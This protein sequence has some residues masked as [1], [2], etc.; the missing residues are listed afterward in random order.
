MDL[1]WHR[2]DLRTWDNRAVYEANNFIPIYIIDTNLIN[3]DSNR[4]LQWILKNIDVLKQTYR[5]RD[6]DLIVRK[7]DPRDILPLI[8]EKYN[9]D[10]VHWN[11]S[12]TPIGK[13]RDTTV[14]S[15]LQNNEHTVKTYDSK[16][17]HSLDEITT[18][19]TKFGTYYNEWKSFDIDS[20]YEQVRQEDMH[21]FTD[22]YA[23]PDCSDIASI[24]KPDIPLPEPGIKAAR[25]LLGSFL[26]N[27]A[28]SYAENKDYPAEYN[29]SKLSF[30]L[31][32]GIIGIR[33]VMEQITIARAGC[34]DSQ[35]AN[36]NEFKKQIAWRDFYT[37]KMQRSTTS[38]YET[39][40]KYDSLWISQDNPH[41][42]MYL[43]K[44][45]NG[46]TG[47]PIIDAGMRE[48]QQTG[49]M[50]NRL[51][52]ATA[53]FLTNDLHISWEYGAKWFRKMLVDY[54]PANNSGGWKWISSIGKPSQEYYMIVNPINQGKQYDEDAEYIKRYVEELRDIPANKIHS[55]A[56]LSQEQRDKYEYPDPIIDHSEERSNTITRHEE[57]N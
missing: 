40:D 23:V 49:Y 31:S 34:T 33:E 36:I 25:N 50:H 18:S 44:W 21:T 9:I 27:R 48:L 51:R 52:M 5:D 4:R 16:V 47:Y 17:L 12:Y 2:S 3:S 1:V 39:D 11:N 22:E 8:A 20:P 24:D 54:D 46:E 42:E 37:H 53:S 19:L 10:T 7:G 57:L 13:S 28:H 55:W 14:R 56:E 41:F 32:Y 15:I 6:S 38:I 35:K 45:K 26:Q 30:Y 43:Q 29:T